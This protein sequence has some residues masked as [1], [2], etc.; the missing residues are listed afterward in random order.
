MISPKWILAS[1][2]RELTARISRGNRQADV[3]P[4]RQLRGA[5]LSPERHGQPKAVVSPRGPLS[6]ESPSS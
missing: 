1:T 4:W 2:S 5:H 3:T 6:V